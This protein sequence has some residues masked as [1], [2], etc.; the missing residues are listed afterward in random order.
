MGVE[1][2]FFYFC[3]EVLPTGAN[4]AV[5]VDTYLHLRKAEIGRGHIGLAED[6]S[7]VGM[8]IE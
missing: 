1:A 6:L 2:L 5:F 4:V 7:F 3:L 8:E